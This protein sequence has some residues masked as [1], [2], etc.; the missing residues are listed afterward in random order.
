MKCLLLRLNRLAEHLEFWTIISS[1]KCT[2]KYF[3]KDFFIFLIYRCSMTNGK[4]L[5][6]GS[7]HIKCQ[8][9]TCLSC[10]EN[11]CTISF[12]FLIQLNQIGYQTIHH[13]ELHWKGLRQNLRAC[14]S[15]PTNRNCIQ[16]HYSTVTGVLSKS[17]HK[18][19]LI[20][21]STAFIAD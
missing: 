1:W 8:H 12:W 21:V 20:L 15:S 6:K 10:S 9:L 13:Y 14:L 5:F 7:N 17:Y 11:K 2:L 3:T 4:Y 16:P 18:L 19:T